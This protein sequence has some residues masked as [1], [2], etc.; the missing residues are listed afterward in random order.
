MKNLLIAASLLFAFSGSFAQE[1]GSKNVKQVK[2]PTSVSREIGP[3][4]E[5][6]KPR[7]Y[8]GGY[9]LARNIFRKDGNPSFFF[10][11]IIIKN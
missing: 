5:T 9:S 8:K 1:K 2:A 10:E 11:I 3:Q 4:I 6:Y 7:R